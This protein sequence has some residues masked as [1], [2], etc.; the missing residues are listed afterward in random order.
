MSEKIIASNTNM[1]LFDWATEHFAK[2]MGFPDV[3]VDNDQ[4]V[5]PNVSIGGGQ[6]MT[7]RQIARIGQLLLNKGKW[8]SQTASDGGSSGGD[9]DDALELIDKDYM[10]RQRLFCRRT[11]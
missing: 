5:Y 2:P 8:P 6:H 3:F 1:T 4:Y 10:V 11:I 7:C 9:G